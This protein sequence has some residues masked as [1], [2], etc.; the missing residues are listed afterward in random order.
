MLGTL[1]ALCAQAEDASRDSWGA[2]QVS[3]FL[4]GSCNPTTWRKNIAVPILQRAGVGFFN[5]QVDEWSEDLV[6]LEAV[7]KQHA[8]ILLFVV[9]GSA[10]SIA[11]MVEAAELVAAGRR[12][13]LVLEDIVDGEVIAGQPV[14]GRELKDLNRARAYLADVAQRHSVVCFNN[15]MTACLY[16]VQ[17]CKRL[18]VTADD[19]G[20][21]ELVSSMAQSAA[22]AASAAI[23]AE[24]AF[25][26]GMKVRARFAGKGH[27]YPA[28]IS[29]CN[30]DG[31]YDL[32]YLDGD[33]E[34]GA[35][36]EHIV[37]I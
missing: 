1:G 16:A 5:P 35:K 26:E 20:V 10:R 14:T 30:A 17:W 22:L 15:V 3:V 24:P 25:A 23:A 9:N 21:E 18:G 32:T 31:T 6:A 27:F 7:R 12:V 2:N 36:A 37:A 34:E 13:V 8:S 11:S 29:K 28:R 4:G 19:A 33:W